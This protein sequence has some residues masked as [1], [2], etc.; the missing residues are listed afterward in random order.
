MIRET[1]TNIKESQSKNDITDS[2][3]KLPSRKK[4]KQ[5]LGRHQQKKKLSTITFFPTRHKKKI[6]FLTFRAQFFS[7][8]RHLKSNQRETLK[9]NHK[10]AKKEKNPLRFINSIHEFILHFLYFLKTKRSKKKMAKQKQRN[11]EEEG[12]RRENTVL[13]QYKIMIQ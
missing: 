5:T 2:K 9:G 3:L 10:K 4:I 13:P 8:F 11:E 1:R 12:E 6:N 7:I